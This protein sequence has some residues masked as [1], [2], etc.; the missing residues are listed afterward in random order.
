M[1]LKLEVGISGAE[2][3][4]LRHDRETAITNVFTGRP[5]RGIVN[6]LMREVGPMADVAPVVINLAGVGQTN[7]LNLNG[8]FSNTTNSGG[9]GFA[10]RGR[11]VSIS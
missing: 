4:S 6:R 1:H 5:A 9:L 2:L 10:L 3:L 8:G 11:T 7:V